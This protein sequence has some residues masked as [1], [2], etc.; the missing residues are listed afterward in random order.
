VDKPL[1]KYQI[2]HGEGRS[3]RDGHKSGKRHDFSNYKCKR[4]PQ[5]LPMFQPEHSVMFQLEHY[6]D[7]FRLEHCG[8]MFRL[9]HCDDVFQ[10]EQI[11]RSHT[12]QMFQ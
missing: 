6:D 2:I 5:K 12:L 9:E 10:P 4:R 8:D 11:K 7:M 3:R 1:Y